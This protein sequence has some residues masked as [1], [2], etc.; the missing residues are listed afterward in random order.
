MCREFQQLV[1]CCSEHCPESNY[2]VRLPLLRLKLKPKPF[3]VLCEKAHELGYRPNANC[4][5]TLVA[6]Y[7]PEWCPEFRG[8]GHFQEEMVL[9]A[10]ASRNMMQ[11]LANVLV[12]CGTCLGFGHAEALSLE[13]GR[14]HARLNS[15]PGQMHD[16]AILAQGSCQRMEGEWTCC[17]S[18]ECGEEGMC[19][20][21]AAAILAST[22]GRELA[23][24]EAQAVA[25]AAAALIEM[26]CQHQNEP[27]TAVAVDDDDQATGVDDVIVVSGYCPRGC[28][29][30][31]F[32][33]N[34]HLRID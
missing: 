7:N 8:A 20:F 23:R 16:P 9:S 24:E 27:Q 31:N 13:N 32:G 18:G 28:K 26:S 6:N 4:M 12:F 22:T 33:R 29:K 14:P 17:A 15:G 2:G 19:E 30:C 5:G 11:T 1:V 25:T 34:S 10:V 21:R 3:Y